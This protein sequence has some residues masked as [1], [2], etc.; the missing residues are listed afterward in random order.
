[1]GGFIGQLYAGYEAS[2]CRVLHIFACLTPSCG[3]DEGS[4]CVQRSLWKL[5][6]EHSGGAV[7]V[8]TGPAADT[9][10]RGARCPRMEQAEEGITPFPAFALQIYDEPAALPKSFERELEL[11]A[12]YRQ[13]EWAIEDAGADPEAPPAAETLADEDGRGD[14]WFLKFQH[15]LERSPRQVVRYSW[16]GKPL[17]ISDPPEEASNS[18]WPP[19]CSRCGAPRIFELQLLPTLLCEVRR[20][21]PELVGDSDIEWG[22]VLVYTCSGDCCSDASCRE[23]VVVQPAV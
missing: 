8:A 10:F 21:C 15:R 20:R 18:A 19:P 11:L 7:E 17:W 3:A 4:W 6:P 12:R 1:M 13:S 14:S 2:H 16:G 5:Q 9:S 22:T 23:F